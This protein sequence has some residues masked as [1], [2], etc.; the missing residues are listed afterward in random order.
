MKR[1]L[2]VSSACGVLIAIS[3]VL[4]ADLGAYKAPLYAAPAFSWTGFYIGGNVGSG[5][6][7]TESSANL[8]VL[9]PLLAPGATLSATLPVTSQTFNGFL[10]G[11]QG[12]YNWQFGTFVLGV[13]GDFDWSGLQGNAPCVLL[14]NC[15]TQHKYIADVTGRLGVVAF[16]KA[17]LY[18]KG[19]VAWVDSDYTIG[20][21]AT[22]GLGGAS[23]SIAANAA[24]SATR[25]GG[26]LGTGIEY[27]FLPN[28]SA[29]IEY[30]YIDIG[31]DTYNFNFST[32]PAT[33][34]VPAIP[35][36]INESV[37]VIKAGVNWRFW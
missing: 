35:I 6:G 22:I 14:F 29:K 15:N 11:V 2:L 8:G 9:G 36:A 37:H 26:L 1:L 10:G 5:W 23:A 19:G 34:G 31:K 20:N 12:G 27:A 13:E 24:A 30:N 7:T 17:L 4:A 16:D 3:P 28:W 32:V 33:T 21:S 18:L 25:T